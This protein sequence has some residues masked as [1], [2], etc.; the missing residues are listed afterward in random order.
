MTICYPAWHL[1][2]R[3]KEIGWCLLQGMSVKAIARQ[4]NL[5]I[6]TV[7]EH[8]TLLHKELLCQ[9]AYQA[10]HRLSIFFGEQEKN[11]KTPHF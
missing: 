2:R 5:S 9:N 8:Q 11:S 7:R 10:G 3:Q 4:L 1:T 6:T